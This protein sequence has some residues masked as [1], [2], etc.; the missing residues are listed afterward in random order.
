[1]EKRGQKSR[2]GGGESDNPRQ[3]ERSRKTNTC[4]KNVNW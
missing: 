1:M 4:K 3:G 2:G